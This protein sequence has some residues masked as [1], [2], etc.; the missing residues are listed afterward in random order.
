MKKC[1]HCGEPWNELGSPGTH[2]DCLKCGY[3]LHSCANCRFY[4]KD[5][6]E[7]CREPMARDEKS[8]YPDKFNSCTW[9]VFLDPV[10]EK[11]NAEKS[12]SAR[13]ALEQLFKPPPAKK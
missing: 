7:W 11:F 6:L 10:E 3:A 1:H 5:A 2:E 9:F 13:M 8:N 12:K 4:D